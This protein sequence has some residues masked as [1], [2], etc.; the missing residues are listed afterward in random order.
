MRRQR[1][2][3]VR[4]RDRAMSEAKAGFPQACAAIGINPRNPYSPWADDYIGESA[5]NVTYQ[6]TV[7]DLTRYAARYGV[8]V[9]VEDT[10]VVQASRARQPD[11]TFPLEL[12]QEL[13]SAESWDERTLEALCCGVPPATYCDRDEIAP[14]ADREGARNQIMAAIRS[15]ELWAD[16]KPNAGMAERMYKCAWNI[17]PTRA[18]RWALSRFP[19]FPEWLSSSKLREIYELQD[20]EK[21]AKGRYTLREAAE[22]IAASGERAEPMIEKLLA[23]A[24][25]GALP[26]YGPGESALHQY[27]EGKRARSYYEEAYWDD[28]NSWLS[29]N[30]L[31][32]T[33]RFPPPK[34]QTSGPLDRPPRSPRQQA[35]YDAAWWDEGMDASVWWGLSNV[36][37]IDAAMLLCG[38]N[39]NTPGA[40]DDAEKVTHHA[41][42]GPADYRRM[43]LVFCDVEQASPASRALA[44]WLAVAREKALT[45]HSW[46]DTWL[47]ATGKKTSAASQPAPSAEASQ[48]SAVPPGN[49][50]RHTITKGKSVP[51]GAEVS[52]A[53]SLALDSDDATT[54]WGELVKLA[55]K[56]VGSL[57]GHSSDG[58]QYRGARYQATGEPDVFTLKNLRDRLQ[59]AKARKG[60]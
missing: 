23:A 44:E 48:P 21:R 12:R 59:R 26:T 54:V 56:G 27:T 42:T 47:A 29:K 37:G 53:R 7:S 55:E 58:V 14:K 10:P 9:E 28:L 57:I 36:S 1:W 25:S 4:G 22:T 8:A 13:V 17:S 51:L 3:L 11:L 52:Q 19:Q 40:A 30:E 38:F 16:P 20:A 43:R 6:I 2:E 41:E 46:M 35:E 39:P 50:V 33:F 15:G 49:V 60:S 32:I 34:L 18:V 5:Q 24:E 45:Y 31:R